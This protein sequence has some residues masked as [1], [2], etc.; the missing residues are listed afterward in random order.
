MSR[1][2]IIKVDNERS[3]NPGMVLRQFSKK[4]S[5]SGLLRIARSFRYHERNKSELA[6]KNSALKRLEKRTQ[7]Q[8]LL[9]LG[10]PLPER[11]RR[12]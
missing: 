12:R 4:V 7:I 2:A 5:G 11:G 8:T 9:K 10:K 6:G 3:Q 1:R